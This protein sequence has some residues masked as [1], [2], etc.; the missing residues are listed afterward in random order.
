VARLATGLTLG[1]LFGL[2]FWLVLET[3]QVVL[4]TNYIIII[5]KVRPPQISMKEKQERGKCGSV[6]SQSLMGVVGLP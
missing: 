4:N 1:L 6:L 5:I 3:F 2:V